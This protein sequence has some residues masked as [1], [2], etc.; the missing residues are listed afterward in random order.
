[1]RVSI[2]INNYNYADYVGIA[3]ESGLHQTYPDIEIIAVDDGSKDDSL[4]VLKS[5][6]ASVTVVAKANGGQGSAYNLGFARSSGDI[7]IFLDAD[8]WLY[9]DA[10]S[11]IVNAWRPGVAKIQFPLSLVDRRG[12]PLG[13]QVPRSMSDRGAL[14]LVRSFGTY[15]SPPASGNAYAAEFLRK[16]M[17]MDESQWRIAADTV[18]IVL[19]PAYGEVVSILRPLGAYRLHR[20]ADGDS[21]LLN[22]APSG[23]WHDYERIAQSKH[24]VAEAF[25]KLHQNLRSPLLLAP[26][27][28][29]VAVICARFGGDAPARCGGSNAKVAWLALY[30]VMRWP[31]WRLQQ[32]LLQFAW[33][34]LVLVLPAAPA[35]VLA[36]KHKANVGLP[37]PPL[38][39]PVK[40]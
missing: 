12:D 27:E 30:S 29:R 26:W 2:L 38:Y 22:N 39:N 1:M 35:R 36:R 40:L 31:N 20:R 37:T 7:V 33:M 19:A 24:L 21:L 18:P 8:D 14:D 9:P 6:G 5:Y 13:R 32:K 23:L 3:V 17:P 4:R 34:V 28:A 25:A 16:I 15:N 11:E 10:V